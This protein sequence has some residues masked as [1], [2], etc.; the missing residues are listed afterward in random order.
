MFY[1]EVGHTGK[2]MLGCV[3]ATDAMVTGGVDVHIKLR[4]GLYQ[5]LAVFRSVAQ[6]YIVVG[7]TMHQQQCTVQVVHAIHGR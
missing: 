7:C 1:K 4:V 5:C 6:V 3:S 2:Q